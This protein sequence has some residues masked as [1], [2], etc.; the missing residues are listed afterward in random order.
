[1]SDPLGAAIPIPDDFPVTWAKAEDETRTWHRETTHCPETQPALAYSFW[2]TI[3]N[4]MDRS[5]AYSDEPWLPLLRWINTYI[6]VSEKLTVDSEEED[7]A[8]QRAKEARAA[9]G[10]NVQA[11]WQ[12]EFLPEIQGYL[13]RWDAV[14]LESVT[15]TQ[16]QRHIDET[17]DGLLQIWTL[18][19]RLG[20]GQRRKAFTDYYKELFGD[21]ADLSVVHRLVQGLPNKTTTMGRALWDLSR[22]AP[23]E[24]AEG[25]IDDA[26]AALA[27]STAGKEFLDALNEFL[28]TYGHRGNHWGLQYP[29]WIEDPTPV[30]VMLRGCLA[31]PERDPEAVFAAQAAEREQAL[32]EVRG[33]YRGKRRRRVPSA[34]RRSPRC[35]REQS[36]REPPSDYR[37]STSQTPT[38]QRYRTTTSPRRRTTTAQRDRQTR[39]ATAG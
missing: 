25:P 37:R 4:G 34:F 24:F 39:Q 19:F 16:L 30:L 23:A 22:H 33:Q 5:R 9:F 13:D 8:T 28:T 32:S 27:Q 3:W 6:Y 2:Q 21:D 17:W 11:H 15:T 14:D 29:T 10:E 12:D 26:R 7:A 20:S 18:H 38:I 31:D 35:L 36:E 1:M